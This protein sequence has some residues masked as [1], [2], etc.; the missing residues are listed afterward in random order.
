MDRHQMRQVD[1]CIDL[2]CGE[3]AV[4]E[5]FLD[6]A[7]VHTR[8]QKMG[9]ECVTQRVRVEMTEIRCMADGAVELTADGPVAEAATA[10]IDK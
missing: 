8:L 3:G 4:A 7:K 1:L 10:L 9:G 5:E 2:G 6:R